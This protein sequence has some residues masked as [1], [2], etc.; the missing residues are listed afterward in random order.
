MEIGF[1]LLPEYWGKGIMT[2]GLPLIYNYGFN[3]LGLHRIERSVETENTICKKAIAKLKF[4]YEGTM[5]DCEIKNGKFI[6]LDIYAKF[7]SN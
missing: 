7:K 3:H 1:W 5:K 4:S 2:E 6:S